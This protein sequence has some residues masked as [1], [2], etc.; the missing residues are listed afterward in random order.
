M[1]LGDL[2]T[3]NVPKIGISQ[4]FNAEKSFFV[5]VE[6]NRPEQREVGWHTAPDRRFVLWLKG[7]SEQIASDGDVRSF[8]PGDVG[9]FE[10]TTGKGHRSLNLS[11]ALL[12]F[13]PLS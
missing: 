9:L 5:R 7:E 6:A 1:P 3:A 11:D 4:A 8:G 2:G 13:I 12:A 10:D